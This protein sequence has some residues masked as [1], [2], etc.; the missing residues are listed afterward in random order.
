MSSTI[1]TQKAQVYSLFL[2][3]VRTM[4][5]VLTSLGMCVT[6]PR[7]HILSRHNIAALLGSNCVE[8]RA[9]GRAGSA[10]V[11]WAHCS[12]TASRLWWKM[13]RAPHQRL[14]KSPRTRTL[15]AFV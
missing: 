10:P 12:G 1:T 11:G 13:N 14:L 6:P 15:V 9:F 2:L 8:L 4:A 3:A 5:G 7:F